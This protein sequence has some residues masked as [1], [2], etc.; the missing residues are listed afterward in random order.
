[1]VKALVCVIATPCCAV[2]VWLDGVIVVPTLLNE[3]V[4]GMTETPFG[5]TAE[6]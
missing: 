4:A 5:P 6:T 1:M 3:M 2:T